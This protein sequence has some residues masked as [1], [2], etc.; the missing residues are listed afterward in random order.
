MRAFRKFKRAVNRGIGPA[1]WSAALD[2][3][4]AFKELENS[5]VCSCLQSGS[6][7]ASKPTRGWMSLEVEKG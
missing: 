2:L 7:R 1:L 4:T 3:G 5:V 6:R